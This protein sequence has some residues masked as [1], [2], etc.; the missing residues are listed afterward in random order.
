M[1]QNGH[2]PVRPLRRVL[3]EIKQAAVVRSPLKPAGSL[4]RQTVFCALQRFARRQ[5]DHHHAVNLVA[6]EID[7]VSQESATRGGL[8]AVY[9]AAPHDHLSSVIEFDCMKKRMGR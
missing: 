2:Q 5:V 6:L 7:R 4:L 3:C 9:V 1:V 8:D